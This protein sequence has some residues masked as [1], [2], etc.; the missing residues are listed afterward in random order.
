MRRRVV[1]QRSVRWGAGIWVSAQQ[2]RVRS[3][4]YVGQRSSM[5]H[6]HQ[7]L[8]VSKQVQ[9]CSDFR[10]CSNTSSHRSPT[11]G[12][13]SAVNPPESTRP[14][15]RRKSV[16]GWWGKGIRNVGVA[17]ILC[18]RSPAQTIALFRLPDQ[19]PSTST[20]LALAF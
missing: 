16:T 18:D 8:A 12:S 6:E 7:L 19:P 9:V 4:R 15:S 17:R 2:I 3:E 1:Q 11:E 13:D 5:I 20:R 10:G 14:E